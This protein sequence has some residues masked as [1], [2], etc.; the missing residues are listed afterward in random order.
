MCKLCIQ[1]QSIT[2]VRG[3][4]Q[5]GYLM[6]SPA[7]LTILRWIKNY[8]DQPIVEKRNMG[9]KPSVFK[10][11]PQTVKCYFHQHPTRSLKRAVADLGNPN[12]NIQTIQ[13]KLFLMFRYLRRR[14]HQ[15]QLQCF[16]QCNA[17]SRSCVDNMWLD[18]GSWRRIV[19]WWMYLSIFRISEHSE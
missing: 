9:K 13:W 16:A 10:Q 18:S 8:N 14:G 3:N 5:T 11:V 19:F 2:A 6:S 1:I 12:S 15:L 17:F 7:S 4:C